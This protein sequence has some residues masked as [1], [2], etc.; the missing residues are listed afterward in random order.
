MAT[1]NLAAILAA[2]SGNGASSTQNSN[3]RFSEAITPAEF[4]KRFGPTYKLGE[5]KNKHRYC[6]TT[7]DSRG[8][9]TTAY[10]SEKLQALVD[11]TPAGQAFKLPSD[12]LVAP[13]TMNSG[14]SGWALYIQAE[15]DFTTKDA[16]FDQSI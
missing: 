2:L 8:V 11:K 15:I 10:A 4:V 12:V 5:T 7:K 6:L 13:W 9:I 16:R 14:E 1:A 3:T